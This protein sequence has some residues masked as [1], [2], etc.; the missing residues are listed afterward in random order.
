MEG[1]SAPDHHR[2][3][4]GAP[5]VAAAGI[6][7]VLQILDLRLPGGVGEHSG[8]LSP[9]GRQDEILRGAHGRQSQYYGPSPQLWGGGMQKAT[10]LPDLCPQFP[11]PRQMQVDGPGAQLAST[12]VADVRLAASGQDRSQ[13]NGGRA[14]FPHQYIRDGTPVQGGGVHR[15]GVLLPPG[16]A[17]QIPQDPDGCVH[18]PQA[19]TALQ[20]HLSPRQQ[21][22]GQ[23]GEHAVFRALDA[24][25]ALQ[26]PAAA[27]VKLVHTLF[28]PLPRMAYRP[29]LW[30][31]G[32]FGYWHKS[33]IVR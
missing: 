23:N 15:Q 1:P 33:R 10:L 4:A 26:C 22:G 3:G 16:T 14:H 24:Y 12:G 17:S 20:A 30:K 21:C 18:V 8:P 27:D 19:G 11:Q 32:K 5:D 13:K 7:E 2:G 25:L 31:G 28:P 6:E 29:I 9:A